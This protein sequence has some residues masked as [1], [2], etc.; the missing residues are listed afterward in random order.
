MTEKEL[1]TQTK[2]VHVVNNFVV[3]TLVFLLV[4]NANANAV[5]LSDGSNHR[6][7]IGFSKTDKF[8]I[9]DY[10]EWSL[11]SGLKTFSSITS[12]YELPENIFVL[13]RDYNLG[14]IAI[15]KELY[16]G[17][18]TIARWQYHFFN[19]EFIAWNESVASNL[20]EDGDYWPELFLNPKLNNIGCYGAMPLRYGDFGNE[21][22]YDLVIFLG[23]EFIVFSP[24]EEGVIFSLQYHLDDWMTAEETT[25][26]YDGGAY[27]ISEGDILP[28]YQSK[29]SGYAI[30]RL[31]IVASAYRGHSK[32]FQGDL[33]DDGHSD[34]IVWNKLYRSRSN[35][36]LIAG[37]ELISNTWIHYE[38]DLTA[39][40]ES[41][42]GVTGEY[43]PQDTPEADIQKWLAENNLTWSKGY[44][45]KSECPGE[46]GQLIPEMHDPLLNDPEVLQ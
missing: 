10:E 44:P 32:V 37:F 33:D 17:S 46:E 19:P 2:G 36:D 31:Q 28:Q 27:G 11:L 26:F 30:E 25:A 23:N 41:E 7:S 1:V 38:R 16:V 24:K 9:W 39:Q 6:D 3:I 34:L 12:F 8:K 43:L 40:A 15:Q 14:K 21:G 18:W 20:T 42:A 5:E 22:T 13:S 4:A 29:T 45:A 35:S